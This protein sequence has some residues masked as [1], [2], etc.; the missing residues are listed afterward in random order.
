MRHKTR[1]YDKPRT[2]YQRVTDSGVLPPAKAAELEALFNSTNPA[3]LTRGITDIQLQS[4]A[5]PPTRPRQCVSRRREK[6]YVRHT[7]P[8]REHLD[9]RHYGGNSLPGNAAVAARA[10]S[11]QPEHT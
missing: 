2:P 7:R 4:S 6:K 8:F 9:V 5:S 3:D 10:H 1:V 11:A